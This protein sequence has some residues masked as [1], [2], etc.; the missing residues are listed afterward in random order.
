MSE[1][2]KSYVIFEWPLKRLSQFEHKA[3]QQVECDLI[4]SVT[5]KTIYIIQ[6]LITFSS[7]LFVSVK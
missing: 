6:S 2:F 3:Y 7:I 5:N 1:N 4:I